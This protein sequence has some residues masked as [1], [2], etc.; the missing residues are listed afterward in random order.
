MDGG[1]GG[2][3]GGH[4]AWLPGYI[5][6]FGLGMALALWHT[7]RAVGLLRR[8]WLDEIHRHPGTVWAL[9]GGVYL[10]AISP[11]AG[12]YSL[13]PPAPGEAVV[14]S[15]LYAGLGLLVV[16]PAVA[17]PR[18]SDDSLAVRRLGGR[19]GTFFGDISY[20]IFCYH[21]IVLGLIEGAIGFEVF[22]GGFWTL[23][24]PT[25]VGTTAVATAS[26]YLVERPVMRWG[27]RNER[28]PRAPAS[29]SRKDPASAKH[30]ASAAS[31]NS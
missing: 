4:R 7:A 28:N 14:K 24:I 12:P 22:S 15:L 25:L 31:T 8:T 23:L 5:G 18:A 26:F 1:D 29:R 16:L 6:W 13:V 10:V 11:V 19:T 3:R 20:G 2:S 21:L 30:A 17:A 27:R 9:A